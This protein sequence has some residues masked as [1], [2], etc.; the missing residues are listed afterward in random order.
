MIYNNFCGEKVSAL[1]FGTM[2]F[3]TLDGDISK[4]DEEKTFEMFDYGISKGINY[5]DTAW[6][7]HNG[8][9]EVVVGK[10]LKRYPRESFF[11]TTKNSVK[12]DNNTKKH[13]IAALL[14][15]THSFSVIC[16]PG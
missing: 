3:P 9:S 11:L 1:G 5:F 8:M 4:I 13:F 7:Y 15:A 2:R 6:G 16:I 14:F 10:A 12:I